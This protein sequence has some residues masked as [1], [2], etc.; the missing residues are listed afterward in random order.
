V[1]LLWVAITIPLFSAFGI[2]FTT[3]DWWFWWDASVD[4]YFVVDV[5][6]QFRTAYWDDRGDFLSFF[7]VCDFRE[8]FLIVRSDVFWTFEQAISSPTFKRFGGSICT[9]GSC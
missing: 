4:F 6:I 7:F 8:L 1:S 3:Q 9:A 5:V 2:E